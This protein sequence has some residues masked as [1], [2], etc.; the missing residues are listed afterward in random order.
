MKNLIMG[1]IVTG[2]VSGA[3]VSIMTEN[4]YIPVIIVFVFTVLAVSIYIKHDL[5]NDKN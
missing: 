1:L 3:I 4:K 5:K 2:W